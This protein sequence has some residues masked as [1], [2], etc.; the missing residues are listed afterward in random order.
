MTGIS[1]Q[2]TPGTPDRQQSVRMERE[3][4]NVMG[5]DTGVATLRPEQPCQNYPFTSVPGMVEAGQRL[6][7]VGVM[8]VTTVRHGD[9]KRLVMPTGSLRPHGISLR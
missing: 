6:S 9:V 1:L 4:V 8:K 2:L 3:L 5:G 7:G